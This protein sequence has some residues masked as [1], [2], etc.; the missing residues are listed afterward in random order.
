MEASGRETKGSG[1]AAAKVETQ[2]IDEG[3]ATRVKV[4]TDLD[5]TGK[6]A[7][8]GRG[9]MSDVAGKLTDQFAAC[10]AKQV[11]APDGAI[12]E[13]ARAAA[14]R[15]AAGSSGAQ[16]ASTPAPSPSATGGPGTVTVQRQPVAADTAD[17]LDLISTVAMPLVK[18]FAPALAG[19]LAGIIAGRLVGR[20]R[21]F[22]IVM[23][24]PPR[25]G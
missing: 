20:R 24:E 2:M 25:R 15:S 6:P 12:G 22:I 14:G 23:T 13:G 18:R 10:L 16:A 4:L 8:F 21:R 17:S 1:T 5:V 19:L 9:V 3:S 11:Q 7:Q